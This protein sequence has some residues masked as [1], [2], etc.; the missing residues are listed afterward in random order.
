MG[1]PLVFN[2]LLFSGQR[3]DRCK[4]G[5]FYIDLENEFGCTPCFCYGH[6]SKCDLSGGYTKSKT[7]FVIFWAANIGQ[8][9]SRT[10]N[11][12]ALEE[13][14]GSSCDNDHC[15]EP[16]CAQMIQTACRDS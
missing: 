3:C 6:T 9:Y 11:D 1:K 14:S 4:A 2:G 7:D 15:L 10:L 8:T 5:H 13:S 12:D 16:K